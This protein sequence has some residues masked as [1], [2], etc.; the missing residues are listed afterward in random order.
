ME[1]HEQ[2]PGSRFYQSSL[3][4]TTFLQADKGSQ[5]FRLLIP[6]HFVVWTCCLQLLWR[7]QHWPLPELLS[8]QCLAQ[9]LT[10]AFV[11]VDTLCEQKTYCLHATLVNGWYSSFL[12]LF[13]AFVRVT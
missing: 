5:F 2:L 11:N 1:R 7:L 8:D 13:F 3:L 10:M 9:P 4:E 12:L 6:T